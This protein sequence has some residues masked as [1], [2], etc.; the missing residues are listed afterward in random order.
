MISLLPSSKSWFETEKNI[1]INHHEIEPLLQSLIVMAWMVETRDPYTGGHLWRVSQYCRLLAEDLGLEKSEVARIALGGFLH[2]LGKISVPDATLKK[3]AR[4]SDQEYES[5]KNHPEV[6]A[7]IVVGHPLAALV[8]SAILHHHER[9]DGAGYPYGLDDGNLSVDSRIVSICDAFDAMTSTRP[10]RLGMS[11]DQAL[12]GIKMNLHTQFDGNFGHIFIELG[13][14]GR[15]N[16]ILGHTDLG[17]PLQTCLTCGPTMVVRR[18][19]KT[20]DHTYCHNCAAEAVIEKSNNKIEIIAT[21]LKGSSKA[22]QPNV[23]FDLIGEFV[24]TSASALI[25]Q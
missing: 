11:M 24:T 8:K 7:R 13:Q 5:I 10:Y 9:P 22:L 18:N 4:L 12:K 2:D 6:G 23:D 15:L 3:P 14:A 20:G 17:I 25:V 21:G 16:H 19:Q 1:K